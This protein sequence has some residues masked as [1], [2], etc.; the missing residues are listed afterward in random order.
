MKVLLPAI[1]LAVLALAGC[2]QQPAE[3]Q[4]GPGAAAPASGPDAKPGI[5]L[6]AGLVLPAV[7]GNPGA[8]YFTLDNASGKTAVLAKVS[9]DGAASTAM[10]RSKGGTMDSVERVEIAPGASL[11][12]EPGKLHVMVFDLDA[13]LQAGGETEMTLSFADGDKLSAPLRIEAPGD[14]AGGGMDHGGDH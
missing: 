14:G 9:I 6:Q 4:A 2:Q 3:K 10:H 5:A 8:A 12:F 13:K 7:K 1:V 11:T